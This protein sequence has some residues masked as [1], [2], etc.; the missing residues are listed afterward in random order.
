M[1]F[2]TAEIRWFFEGDIPEE[3]SEWIIGLDGLFEEQ[4]PRTD[5][6]LQ[7]E[8]NTSLGIKI[9]EGKFEFK[10]R[11]SQET[12]LIAKDNIE[13]YV[14]SWT[15]WSFESVENKYP[16]NEI[17]KGNWIEV[18]KVRNLQKFI[19]NPIGKIS[20]GFDNYRS[21]GCNIELTKIISYSSDDSQSSDEYKQPWWTLG[22]ETY[23][24]TSLLEQ[25]LKIAFNYIFQTQFP[26]TLLK[27]D[28]FGYP[29]W[30]NNI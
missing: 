19:F 12:K 20:D 8:N 15:K 14:E 16:L 2:Q 18:I 4:E 23:G 28:S 22:L 3:I 5:L 10:E 11:H 9:R 1:I 13:G 7:L 26:G 29:Q 6:Y 30:L 25:N 21:D 17:V 27:D 24:A